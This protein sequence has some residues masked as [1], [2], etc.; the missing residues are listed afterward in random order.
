M[1]VLLRAVGLAAWASAAPRA[2]VVHVL[3]DVDE[4]DTGYTLTF[5]GRELN[6]LHA[7]G[8]LCCKS[9]VL[10]LK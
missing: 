1:K 6:S 9:D 7:V 5:S 4:L 8:V 3:V 10:A 2:A